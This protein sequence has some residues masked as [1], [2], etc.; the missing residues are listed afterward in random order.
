MLSRGSDKVTG[1]STLFTADPVGFSLATGLIVASIIAW[2]LSYFT[3]S[4]GML[5]YSLDFRVITFFL[6][7]W[8]VGMVAMMFPSIIPVVSIYNKMTHTL[9]SKFDRIVGTPIFL[10]GYLTLYVALGL[11]AYLAVLFA[12][13]LADMIPSLSSY[14]TL[15]IGVVLIGAGVWQLTPLKEVCLRNCTS[16]LGFFL[17]HSKSGLVGAFRMGAEH[18]Y[19]CVGCCYLYMVVMLVVAGMGIP[20]MALI[21]VLI[22]LEKVVVRGAKWFTRLIAAGF[23]ILGILVWL[24]PGVLRL[25]Q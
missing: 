8:I 11:A 2:A 18:G 15:A 6:L 5:I 7:V 23:I 21:A 4:P 3:M 1:R 22:T 12:H 10:S 13:Q 16:P 20:S 25:I 19:F 14:A 9:A 24:Y 17:T